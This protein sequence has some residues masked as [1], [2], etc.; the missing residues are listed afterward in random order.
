MASGL[1]GSHDAG[2]AV[3]DL[4]GHNGWRSLAWVVVWIISGL[5][6]FMSLTTL[7]PLVRDVAGK[8]L[9]SMGMF[10]SFAR[11]LRAGIM[12]L[13]LIGAVVLP[14][15]VIVRLVRALSASRAANRPGAFK[16]VFTLPVLLASALLVVCWSALFQPF[17]P[18]DTGTLVNF[19][20]GL[21]YLGLILL[22]VGATLFATDRR[23]APTLATTPRAGTD[24]ASPRE[25][26]QR[27]RSHLGAFTLGAL[28]I[29]VAIIG[30]VGSF[31]ITNVDVR[32]IPA[33]GLTV[34]A[35]GMLIGTWVGKAR[36]LAI[37]C[38]LTLPFVAV[39]NI[40]DVPISG[41]WGNVTYSPHAPADL[42]DS[43]SYGMGT[44]TL[45]LSKLDAGSAERNVDVTLAVGDLTVILPMDAHAVIDASTRAGALSLVGWSGDSGLDISGSTTFGRRMPGLLHLTL[46]IGV[47]SI[48]VYRVGQAQP[49]P[50]RP[51]N[52]TRRGGQG[53][54]GA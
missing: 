6:A 21:F 52:H 15:V 47:G 13:L 38:L 29:I 23:P 30:L 28:L 24:A 32:I 33:L 49:K 31:G 27:E 9:F 18:L 39:A 26:K 25:K 16:E 36:W 2:M 7:G 51:H 20:P 8:V 45:D 1:L 53:G 4:R 34:L 46:H 37:L 10:G 48:Q 11:I 50:N 12:L 19:P 35:A 54:G 44:V 14:V 43:Y 3:E 22:C 5:L 41:G 17:G 40:I 42:Q